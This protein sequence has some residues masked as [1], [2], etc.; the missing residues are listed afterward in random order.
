MEEVCIFIKKG[1]VWNSLCHLATRRK[2]VMNDSKKNVLKWN[3]KANIWVILGPQILG[4]LKNMCSGLKQKCSQK[5]QVLLRYSL[6]KRSSLHQTLPEMY[7]TKIFFQRVF[8]NFQ[9]INFHDHP[10]VVV[11]EIT[12]YLA[13]AWKFRF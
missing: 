4:T 9:K 8:R 1:L 13:I 12:C 3:L 6:G 10:W 11:S 2:N 5:L 7:C